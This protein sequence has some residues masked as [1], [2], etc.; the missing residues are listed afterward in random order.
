MT[1]QHRILV[2]TD[3]DG[4]LLNKTDYSWADAGPT[5][6][7]LKRLEIP[8]VLSSSKT[9]AEMR[10]LQDEMEL[11]EAPFISENGGAICW[12]A[13]MSSEEEQVTY[14]GQSRSE[15]ADALDGLRSDFSFVTFRD[16]G[17]PGI[18]EATGLPA[19]RAS[20]AAERH[21]TEPLLWQDAEDR[22]EAFRAQIESHAL[23]LTRGG[24]FWHVAGQTSKGEAMETVIAEYCKQQPGVTW[25]TLAIGDSP[26][27]QSMLDRADE[28]IAI[29]APDGTLHVELPTERGVAASV[30]GSAGWA[31]TVTAVL[32]KLCATHQGIGAADETVS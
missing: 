32:D 31:E 27:D 8:V 14:Q 24:R 28:P 7:R 12:P 30:P 18:M 2:F 10:R 17:V 21:T 13:G 15:I 1:P 6:H 5:L 9:V 22:I 25:T 3:L 20:A 11:A 16:M 26:I 4:C 29:P 23:T 19:D